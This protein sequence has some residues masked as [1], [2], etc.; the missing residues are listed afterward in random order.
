MKRKIGFILTLVLV[1]TMVVSCASAKTNNATGKISLLVYSGA[2]LRIPMDKIKNVYENNNNV[3]IQLTYAGSAHN[4][5][6]I[7]LINKGDVY[8]PG[9]NYYYES[10][11]EK[12][13]SNY[14]LDV[15]Y[16]IP[17]IAVP[18]E[19]LANINSL[20]DLSNP[21]I[22]IILGD[23]GATAIG[24]L[25]QK[26]FKENNLTEKINDNI[27]AKA[28]TV[29]ELVVY[30]SMNQADASLIWEDNVLNVEEIKII[31]IEESKN[32]IKTIPACTLTCSENSEEAKAFVD[33]IA[34]EEGK[35]IFEECGFK[36]IE[37]SK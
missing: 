34:S 9:A 33:F 1:I 2:G 36:S 7:E 24:K 26:I 28:A 29:N 37:S 32:I 6:Q 15:A 35:N 11:N 10:A 25:S 22:K 12:G 17:V 13:L 31:P 21:N 18:K 23:E 3:E 19:N 30:L 27:V 4:L 14:K 16:H 5:S 8:I 20:T